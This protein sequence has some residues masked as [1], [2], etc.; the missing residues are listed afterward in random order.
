MLTPTAAPMMNLILDLALTPADDARLTPLEVLRDFA[1]AS[2]G[3]HYLE[4]ASRHYA[5]EK[6]QD[7]C[8]LRH[9]VLSGSTDVDLAFARRSDSAKGNKALH[10]TVIEPESAERPF[11]AEERDEIADHFVEH[12]RA[13]LD[14]QGRHAELHVERGEAEAL[15]G[16]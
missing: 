4:D 10:L 8:I 14:A 2:P 13:H 15:A 1:Y 11:N 12:L 7:A 5:E 3:W 16:E 6:G 9:H